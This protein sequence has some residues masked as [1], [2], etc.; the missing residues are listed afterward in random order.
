MGNDTRIVLDLETQKAFQEVEGRQPGLLKVSVVGIY[1]YATG[2]YRTFLESE[3][4]ALESLLRESELVIGFN[5]RRFDFLV[6]EPYL[7]LPVAQLPALDLMDDVTRMLGHRVSLDSLADATLGQQKSGSGLDALRFY[8]E[9]KLE[10][11]KAYCLKDVQLTK[12]LYA[13]GLEHGELKCTS[14]FTGGV[15]SIAVNWNT[16]RKRIV[17]VLEEAFKRHL[18]VEMEYVSVKSGG[19]SE[20]LRRAVDIYAYDGSTFEGFCH[21]RNDL[22]HFRVERVLDAR[23]TFMTYQI[24][25]DYRPSFSG[26]QPADVA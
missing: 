19:A 6:L 7:K 16:S 26:S 3:L 9:G 13:Y 12:D 21:L 25:A 24:P 20:R 8:K 10:E 22:R 14:K 4:P 11:L 5:I 18:R 17:H 15:L 1:Q 23:P 2:Q